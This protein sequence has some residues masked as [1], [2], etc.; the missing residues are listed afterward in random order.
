MPVRGSIRLTVNSVKYLDNRAGVDE[1]G[2]MMTI[3]AFAAMEQ[4][5]GR[6][7]E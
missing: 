5:D 3:E 4:S 7:P 2:L 6:D 1:D